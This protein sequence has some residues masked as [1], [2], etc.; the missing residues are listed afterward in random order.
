MNDIH[1]A[2]ITVVGILYCLNDLSIKYPR[3]MGIGCE[4]Y[5]TVKEFKSSKFV[6]LLLNRMSPQDQTTS[7]NSPSSL[8]SVER[9][10]PANYMYHVRKIEFSKA[11]SGVYIF[12]WLSS[13]NIDPYCFFFTLGWPF[14]INSVKRPRNILIWFSWI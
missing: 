1:S 11:I 13:A 9:C 2:L 7:Q 14:K 4:V 3:I 12:T 6:L 8:L 5:K 10:D